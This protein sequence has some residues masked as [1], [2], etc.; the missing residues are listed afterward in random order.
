MIAMKK[1]VKNVLYKITYKNQKKY[2][3]SRP[4]FIKNTSE[5]KEE[6]EYLFNIFSV[7]KILNNP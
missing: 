7:F 1:F 5:D 2:K 4:K 3:Y 6:E